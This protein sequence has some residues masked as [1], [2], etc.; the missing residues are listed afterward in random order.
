MLRHSDHEATP[1]HAG[2]P[3]RDVRAAVCA[4]LVQETGAAEFRMGICL[5]DYL[6]RSRPVAPRRG[7]AGPFLSPSL[8]TM[9][10]L[11]LAAAAALALSACNTDAPDA[12][13]DTPGLD[14]TETTVQTGD[15]PAVEPG[16]YAIDA[17]HSEVGFQVKHLGISNVDGRFSDVDGTVTVPAGGGLA[18]M[19]VEATIQAASID[20]RNDDRDEHLRSPDFF[21]AAR[22]ETLTFRSTG[23]TPTGGSGFQMTGDLTMHGQTHPVTLDGT[24]AGS[25][26]DPMGTR[27]VAFSATGTVDR[28]QWGL[29]WNKALEAGGVVVSDEV[30]LTLE[31]EADQQVP[32]AAAGA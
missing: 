13:P 26:A 6:T 28:T 27:K 17:A 9:T 7:D 2:Q 19:A 14:A 1:A 3:F 32:V 30:Q 24:Y 12:T 8:P 15:A 16:V 4:A 25:A 18:D 23:V 22:F 31:V 20:T 29:T 21:D 5:T 10:R 11:T